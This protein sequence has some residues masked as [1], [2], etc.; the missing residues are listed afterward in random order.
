M[1]IAGLDRC[2]QRLDRAEGLRA[3]RLSRAHWQRWGRLSSSQVRTGTRTLSEYPSLLISGSRK[4]AH[5]SRRSPDLRVS[6]STSSQRARKALP[7]PA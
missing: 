2:T 6:S 4:L 1:S 5:R 7:E 3:Q